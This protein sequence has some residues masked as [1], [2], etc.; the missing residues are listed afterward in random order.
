MG[1][2]GQF[3]PQKLRHLA[4]FCLHT[5]LLDWCE[6]GVRGV[7]SQSSPSGWGSSPPKFDQIFDDFSAKV[8]S[9][10]IGRASC[11]ERV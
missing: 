8:Y 2:S 5:Y 7:R 1:K 6:I 10:Q 3:V 9:P 11:R 4:N